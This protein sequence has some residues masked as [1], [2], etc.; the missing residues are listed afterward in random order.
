MAVHD[1]KK[2]AASLAALDSAFGVS[3][4]EEEVAAVLRREMEGLYDEQWT[5]A[6]GNQCFVRR[7]KNPEKRVLLAAHMDEIGFILKNI[8]R[9]G[10]GRVL[11]VGYHD[12]RLAF[13]QE[14][15][16]VT[17]EGTRVYG[18]T[19]VKPAHVM[20][21]DDRA[22][23]AKISDLFIDFGTQSAEESR[24]LG[25]EIGDYGAFARKGVFLNGSDVFCGKAVDDRAGLA[26]L[27]ETA[28]RLSSCEIEPTVCFAGTVQEEVGMR[29]GRAISERFKPELFFAVDGTLTGGT[30]GYDL[31]ECPQTLG[32][33]VSFKFFDWV[34]SWTC[35]NNVPRRLTRRLI[36]L[37]LSHNIPF[38]RE[39]IAGGGTDA[40][41]A[42]LSGEGVLA[43][44]IGIPMRYM[45]SAVG[46]VRLSDMALAAEYLVHYLKEYRSSE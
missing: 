17:A 43:G 13:N 46:L 14:L 26:V 20:T 5:D 40:W 10:F 4:N 15:V 3:G 28:R 6:L 38:Q 16:F 35:G 9:E 32:G 21:A 2:L 7:G 41:A 33:G 42:S 19:G 18:V 45:H 37:S 23:P 39:V 31:N 44:G 8:D 27:V 25:L 24:A 30:P 1:T 12:D 22:K 34:S 11:P 36:E 29:G